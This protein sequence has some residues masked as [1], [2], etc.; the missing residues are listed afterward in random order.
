M[1]K[2]PTESHITKNSYKV[3]KTNNLQTITQRCLLRYFFSADQVQGH[4]KT[5][6]ENKFGNLMI[7]KS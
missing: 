3:R 5:W 7:L 4:I 1:K 2:M 6:G